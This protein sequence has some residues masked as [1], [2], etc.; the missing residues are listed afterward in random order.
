MED[1]TEERILVFDHDTDT[2]S[3][4]RDLPVYPRL[5]TGIRHL[6]KVFPESTERPCR[7][8]TRGDSFPSEATVA[9]IPR[10]RVHRCANQRCGA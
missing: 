5:D 1:S 10:L 4:W 9:S 3:H 7:H 6:G 2:E 8:G